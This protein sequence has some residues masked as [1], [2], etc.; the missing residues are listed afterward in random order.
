MVMHYAPSYLKIL[1]QWVY[2][3]SYIKSTLI[4][5]CVQGYEKKLL[6]N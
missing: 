5:A 4:F 6:K 3:M 2:K 1:F